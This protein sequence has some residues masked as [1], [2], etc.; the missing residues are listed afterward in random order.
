MAGRSEDRPFSCPLAAGHPLRLLPQGVPNS[1]IGCAEPNASTAA[2]SSRR[3]SVAAIPW[4]RQ[5]RP[6]EPLR[7][8]VGRQWTRPHFR[9]IPALRYR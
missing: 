1:V 5:R 2:S 7:G 9:P 8:P 3:W 6:D 4:R